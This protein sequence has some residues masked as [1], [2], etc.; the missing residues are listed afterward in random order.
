MLRQLDLAE[1]TGKSPNVVKENSSFKTTQHALTGT[2]GNRISATERKLRKCGAAITTC[3]EG[4]EMH[5]KKSL[6]IDG[7]PAMT[8]HI[9]LV[10]R[11]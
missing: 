7:T 9:S 1:T 6:V 4:K 3:C 11:S 8:L 10:V 5:T 2:L